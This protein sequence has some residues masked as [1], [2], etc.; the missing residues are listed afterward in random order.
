MPIGKMNDRMRARHYYA[1]AVSL[2]QDPSADDCK[3]AIELLNK[4][5]ELYPCFS[6]VSIFRQEVWH[7][8]LKSLDPDDNCGTYKEYLDSPAWKMKR[9]AVIER[10]GSQCVCGAQATEVHHKTYDNIGKEPPSDLVALCQKCHEREHKPYRQPSTQPAP[11]DPPGKAYWDQFKTYVQENENQLQLFPEPSGTSIYGIQID[12]K[13]VKAADIRK[14]GAFWLVAYRDNEKLQANLCMQS[15]T[16][17]SLLK[18]QKDIKEQFENNLDELIWEE[19]G[20]R[21]G[22]SDET[23]GP[24]DRAN[25][26][27]E[28]SWLHER[29]LKLHAVF[30]PRVLELQR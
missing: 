25:I 15:S 20:N 30:Q 22:F 2:F 9:G 6:E 24:V 1:A 16:H 7:C 29:L 17:Y 3:Q 23:V 28:F 13:T 10:D 21:I 11:N 5:V 14:E 12:G 26:N 18:K 4:A 27:Q 19:T 8:L